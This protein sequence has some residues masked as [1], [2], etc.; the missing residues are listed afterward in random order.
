MKAK[1]G[2]YRQTFLAK[3]H[4]SEFKRNTVKT[5]VV[6]AFESSMMFGSE[7]KQSIYSLFLKNQCFRMSTTNNLFYV[8]CYF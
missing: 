3:Q 2:H 7:R 5:D 4:L 1:R 6:L 8:I